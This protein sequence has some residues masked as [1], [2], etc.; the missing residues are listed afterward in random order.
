MGKVAS[1]SIKTSL[2]N[3]KKLDITHTHHLN[4]AY[5]E[6]LNDIK[7][8][9]GWKIKTSPESIR[10]LW[11]EIADEDELKIISLV[12]EPVGRNISA[13][14]ENLDVI[15]GKQN[16]HN[17]LS[18]DEL[19][20]GF[21]QNYPHSIP[22][23]WFD[24]EAKQSLGIDVYQ[25]EFPKKE[26]ALFIN[27]GKY[28]MLIMRH[29]MDDSKKKKYI[30]ELLSIKIKGIKRKNIGNKKPYSDVYTNFVESVILPE[31]YLN[32]ML[33]SKY[34]RHFFDKSE[35]AFLKAKW[36]SRANSNDAR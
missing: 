13:Y 1:S 26:G 3:I 35:L 10:K 34:A 6:E 16:A 12:R 25:Y 29:D 14:F 24:K 27:Q 32:E 30:E 15:F 23:T 4:S 21:L 19:L 2:A 20:H 5:T 22:I 31:S 18:Y 7:S 9:K 28:H 8:A 11:S 33:G 36:G 17:I